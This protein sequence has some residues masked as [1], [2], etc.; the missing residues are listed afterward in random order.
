MQLA[1]LTQLTHLKLS[2]L[3]SVSDKGLA[4]LAGLRQLASL[5]LAEPNRATGSGLLAALAPL[6]ALTQLALALPGGRVLASDAAKLLAGLQQL[7]SLELALPSCSDELFEQITELPC[8]QVGCTCLA[9]NHG[10][11]L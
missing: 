1:T 3:W 4:P 11:L 8:L 6:T 9:H 7:A 2:S 5:A 10:R